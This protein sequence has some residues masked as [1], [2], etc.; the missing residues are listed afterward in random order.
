MATLRG[1]L[2]IEP[3]VLSAPS[4]FP[5][6]ITL[7]THNTDGN[8]SFSALDTPTLYTPCTISFNLFFTHES[9]GLALGATREN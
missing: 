7:R 5:L 9:M 2:D 6:H 8:R 3:S 1:I 4:A